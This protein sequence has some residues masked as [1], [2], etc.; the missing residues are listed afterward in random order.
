MNNL[1]AAGSYQGTIFGH[2]LTAVGDR[3]TP[4]VE[5]SVKIDENTTRNVLLWMTD[6]AIEGTVKTLRSLGYTGSLQGLA[7]EQEDSSGLP[8]TPVKLV[9]KHAEYNGKTVERIGIYPVK[10]AGSTG[11]KLERDAISRLEK[12]FKNADSKLQEGGRDEEFE[13]SDAVDDVALEEE[14]APAPP[15]TKAPPK[16][17]VA[18]PRTPAKMVSRGMRNA[19][20]F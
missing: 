2:D 4:C 18:S 13:N 15:V 5:I 16:R 10:G 17:V 9:I 11:T 20:P 3:Q 1:L 19:P 12:L 8:G 14:E 6:R 7:M